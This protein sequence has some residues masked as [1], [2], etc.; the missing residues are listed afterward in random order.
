MDDND[1]SSDYE[2]VYESSDAEYDSDNSVSH[3]FSSENKIDFDDS[4]HDIAAN[5]VTQAPDQ[6]KL[7]QTP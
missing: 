4:S 1:K 2:S 7:T 5:P 3:G 6:G